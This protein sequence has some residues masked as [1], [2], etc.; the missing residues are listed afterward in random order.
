DGRDPAPSPLSFGPHEAEAIGWKIGAFLHEPS[1]AAA[2]IDEYLIGDST[3]RRRV[4][5]AV[6]HFVISAATRT[7]SN[8]EVIGDMANVGG[9]MVRV[10]LRCFAVRGQQGGQ[11][12]LLGVRE[13]V[14]KARLGEAASNG[15]TTGVV[16][17]STWLTTACSN[18]GSWVTSTRPH[19][20]SWR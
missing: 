17:G 14:H 12:R 5:A 1:A 3:L 8:R 13:V 9:V 16:K 19:G 15:V 11:H 4:K 7:P 10:P 2:A 6:A 20:C 18:G